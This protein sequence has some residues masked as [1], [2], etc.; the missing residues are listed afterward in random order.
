M[1]SRGKTLILRCRMRSGIRGG[2]KI[3]EL[4]PCPLGERE[5][6]DFPRKSIDCEVSDEVRHSRRRSVLRLRSTPLGARMYGFPKENHSCEVSDEVRHSWRMNVLK[7][8][9]APH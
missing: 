6:M 1:D 8:R 7:L 9:T 2:G 5:C 3:L 4:D